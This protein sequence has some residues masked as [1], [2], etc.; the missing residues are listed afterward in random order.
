MSIDNYHIHHI[1]PKHMGGTDE[2][3]NLIK[4]TVDAHAE[5]HK[6][7]WEEYGHWQDYLAWQGLSKRVGREELIKMKSYYTHLGKPK[8]EEHRQKLSESHKGKIFTEETKNKMSLAKLGN[9]NRKG[10]LMSDELKKQYSQNMTGI[11]R[12]SYKKNIDS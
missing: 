4:L 9:K 12:G 3:T 8:S 10:K 6:K 7:L 1:L 2:E 5:A 11:K